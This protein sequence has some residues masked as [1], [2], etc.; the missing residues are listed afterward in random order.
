MGNYPAPSNVNGG[1][2]AAPNM[3]APILPPGSHRGG[4]IVSHSVTSPQASASHAAPNRLSRGGT[5]NDSS[6]ADQERETAELFGDIPEA[7]KR[8]FILV[9]D[10]VR[11]GRTRVRVTLDTIDTRS[12]PDSYRRAQ[13]VWP[14][15]WFARE[16]Q[17][18]TTESQF[19]DDFDDDSEGAGSSGRGKTLVRVPMP[20]GGESELGVPRM[21]TRMRGKEV[22]VNDLGYRMAWHQ[23]RTFAGRI[24]M[25]MSL[26][27][28]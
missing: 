12:I 27:P 8:K 21:G 14:R 4:G 20:D 18:P 13:A 1:P 26:P 3:H 11:G 25:S 23:S 5:G 6:E 28:P 19:A 24:G 16:M 9:E 7:K 2:S 10:P 17:S 15:S 22:R